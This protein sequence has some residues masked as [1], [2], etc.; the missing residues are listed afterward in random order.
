M[1]VVV[2]VTCSIGL[3]FSTFRDGQ[4][5]RFACEPAGGLTSLTEPPTGPGFGV[6]SDL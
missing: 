3:E 1:T 4:G 2:L 5:G 6:R